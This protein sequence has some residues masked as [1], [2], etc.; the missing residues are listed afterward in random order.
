MNGCVAAKEMWPAI[1]INHRV[2]EVKKHRVKEVLGELRAITPL[3]L[4]LLLLH[5]CLYFFVC[6]FT[7][8]VSRYKPS[9]IIYSYG[10]KVIWFDVV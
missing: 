10:C 2:Q 6:R 3:T 9:N 8:V 1:A 5:N 7:F 4:W